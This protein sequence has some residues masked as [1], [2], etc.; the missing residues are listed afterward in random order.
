MAALEADCVYRYSVAGLPNRHSTGS[1]GRIRQLINASWRQTRELTAM[2][3]DGGYSQRGASTALPV[4]P[5]VA[6]P[7]ECYVEVPFPTDAVSVVLVVVQKATNQRWIPLSPTTLPGLYDQQRSATFGTSRRMPK[8]YAL[9]TIPDGV[10]QVETAGKI[11]LA[12]VPSSGNYAVWYM[13]GWT[14]RTADADTLPGLADHVE[15]AILGTLIR[16]SEPDGDSQKQVG[17]WLAERARIE[18]FVT[19][20]A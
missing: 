20:R 13:Q 11:L 6:S 17:I 4:A 7:D 3:L 16:M 1:A 8:V 9:Q 19:S 15:H 18:S 14:D 10:G 2:A 5:P 12:P